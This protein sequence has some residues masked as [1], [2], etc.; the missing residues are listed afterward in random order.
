[1]NWGTSLLLLLCCG[2]VVSA[3][4]PTARPSQSTHVATAPTAPAAVAAAESQ[5]AELS[6]ELVCKTFTP[7]G[8][9]FQ[10][11][12]CGTQAQWDRM[13]KDGRDVGEN[14]QRKGVQVGNPTGN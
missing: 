12:V 10:Q 9:R 3:C 11:R 2:L 8:T 14:V 6:Q 7:T 1:V 13:Q 5:S 4:T